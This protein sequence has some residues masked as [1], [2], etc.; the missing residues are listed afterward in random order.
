MPPGIVISFTVGVRV[1][2]GTLLIPLLLTM[3]KNLL[4]AMGF[5]S[6]KVEESVV[7]P[8]FQ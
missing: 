3:I 1:V 2:L 6:A 7:L 5:L 8:E 4:K